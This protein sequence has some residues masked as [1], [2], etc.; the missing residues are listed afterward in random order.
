MGRLLYAGAWI[1]G[2]IAICAFLRLQ[3]GTTNSDAI[4]QS[5]FAAEG[6][7]IG[8]LASQAKPNGRS[9]LNRVVQ[10]IDGGV[11]L[12]PNKE[13]IVGSG[14]QNCLISLTNSD[15]RYGQFSIREKRKEFKYASLGG[16]V[17]VVS[18]RLT[19]RMK[20]HGYNG[21]GALCEGV[22]LGCCKH[23]SAQLAKFSVLCGSNLILHRIG[24]PLR[25]TGRSFSAHNSLLAINQRDTTEDGADNGANGREE[26]QSNYGPPIFALLVRCSRSSE[27][28]FVVGVD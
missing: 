16:R 10:F 4:S 11:N 14:V 26:S 23:V 8:D 17:D 24:L 7:S 20:F 19:D 12:I 5:A 13:A 28:R 9:I 22:H 15:V 3:P 2:F 25:F 21:I 1:V 27:C 18:R 6:V